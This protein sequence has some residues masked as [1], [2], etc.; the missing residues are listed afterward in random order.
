MS[1]SDSELSEL[2]LENQTVKTPVAELKAELDETQQMLEDTLYREDSLR[3]QLK[4]AHLRLA[5]ILGTEYYQCSGC[6]TLV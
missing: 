3:W 6:G 4:K 2:Q 1:D 5:A